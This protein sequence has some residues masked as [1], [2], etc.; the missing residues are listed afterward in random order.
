MH[1]ITAEGCRPS[2]SIYI[3]SC[4]KIMFSQ[5]FCSLSFSSLSFRGGGGG[6]RNMNYNGPLAPLG[7]LLLL[8]IPVD[9]YCKGDVN[10]DRRADIVCTK[11]NG[12]IVVYLSREQHAKMYDQAVMWSED[13]FRFCTGTDKQV[14]YC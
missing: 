2:R 9:L 4:A 12:G 10:K 5:Q 7:P 8:S 3:R 1:L 6:A 13:R 11:N 14:K